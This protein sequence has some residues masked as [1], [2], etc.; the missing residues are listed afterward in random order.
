[1]LIPV[2]VFLLF[3]VAVFIFG[4]LMMRRPIQDHSKPVVNLTPSPI[5]VAFAGAIPMPKKTSDRMRRELVQAGYYGRHAFETFVGT[6]N[7]I[8]LGWVLFIAI[9]LIVGSGHRPLTILGAG[10]LGIVLLYGV[11]GVTLSTLA[12]S[13]SKRIHRSLPDALDM[14]TMMLTGGLGLDRSLQR[15]SRELKG[16]HPDL[17]KEFS[18]IHHQAKVGSFGNSV[19]AFADRLDDPE[20]SGLSTLIQH[21]ERLGSPIS[22]ALIEYSDGIRRTRR[23]RAEEVGNKR[24]VMLLFPVITLLAPPI[25]ILLLGPAM[26]EL[27]DFMNRENQEGGSIRQSVATASANPSAVRVRVR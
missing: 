23:Q 22:E 16:A 3:S 14:L 25:Y 18:I 5:A 20:I 1:M 19:S 12:E 26:L 21:S 27:R 15:T 6:R 2:L 7:G 13:R 8:L 9:L 10:G 4:H 17:A 11:P 24:N